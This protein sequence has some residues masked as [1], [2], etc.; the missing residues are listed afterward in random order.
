MRP[1]LGHDFLT[2]LTCV[3]FGNLV[4]VLD[5]H[6][7]VGR[8]GCIRWDGWRDIDCIHSSFAD[9]ATTL[10]SFTG[11]KLVFDDSEIGS[12]LN[13]PSLGTVKVQTRASPVLQVS[14]NKRRER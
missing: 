2:I 10:T 9:Q 7:P 14:L 5:A 4:Y 13:C 6:S 8:T 3:C 12:S 11:R 1:R